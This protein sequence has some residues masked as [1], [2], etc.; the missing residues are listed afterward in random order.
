VHERL[1]PLIGPAQGLLVN[2]HA[3]ASLLLEGATAWSD[4]ERFLA[5]PAAPAAEA[6]A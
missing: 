6:A 2:P 4:V 1:G 5:E 3:D